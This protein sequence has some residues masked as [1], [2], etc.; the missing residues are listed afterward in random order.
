MNCL[1]CGREI[2]SEQVFCDNCLVS[3]AKHPVDPGTPVQIPK[4]SN[5]PPRVL[6]KKRT[7]PLEEQLRDA[8][9]RAKTA[10]ILALIGWALAIA[11]AYPAVSYLMEDHFAPGQNYTS[12][13]SQSS[14]TITGPQ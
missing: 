14:Q 5:T 12:T 8:K 2:V 10:V 6:T 11:M 9:K 1:K 7:V 3:M 13:T 4:R